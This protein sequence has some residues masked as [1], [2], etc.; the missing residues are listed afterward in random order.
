[1]NAFLLEWIRIEHTGEMEWIRIEHTTININA[2][3]NLICLKQLQI[4][5]SSVST[6]R[7][8]R[9]YIMKYYII[10]YPLSCHIHIFIHD[11]FSCHIYIFILILLLPFLK[12]DAD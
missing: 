3:V 12:I 7:F 10:F 6:V 8:I 1:M 5:D 2:R 11:P 4:L 9:E